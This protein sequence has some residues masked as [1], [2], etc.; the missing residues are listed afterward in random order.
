M[1]CWGRQRHPMAGHRCEW[2]SNIQ[3]MILLILTRGSSRGGAASLAVMN[4]S[5]SD[6]CAGFRPQLDGGDG[7]DRA[8]YQSQGICRRPTREVAADHCTH[9]RAYTHRQDEI[10]EHRLGPI[11]AREPM[12]GYT[13]KHYR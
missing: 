13:C 6:D 8:Q 11:M 12:S 7:E 1:R 2:G 5:I 4:G 3:P 10:R 9:K